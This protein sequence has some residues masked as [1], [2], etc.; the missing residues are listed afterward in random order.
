MEL[1]T[2][3][4]CLAVRD[5]YALDLKPYIDLSPV[6]NMSYSLQIDHLSIFVTE[7]GIVRIMTGDRGSAMTFT[8]YDSTGTI[9]NDYDR[10]EKD[11]LPTF[12]R[13]MVLDDLAGA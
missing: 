10:I 13:L 4:R 8:A 2:R 9:P 6:T 1:E 12:R 5:G 7:D 11:I 3:A